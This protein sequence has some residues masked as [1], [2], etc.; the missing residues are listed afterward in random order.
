MS[1]QPKLRVMQD[2]AIPP[3]TIVAMDPANPAGQVVVSLDPAFLAGVFLP[4]DQFARIAAAAHFGYIA[5]N[6]ATVAGLSDADRE[7][8]AAAFD[9]LTYA[10]VEYLAEYAKADS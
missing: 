2:D 10:D 3:G 8:A 4:A 7:G 1:D 5:W 6:Y 9:A